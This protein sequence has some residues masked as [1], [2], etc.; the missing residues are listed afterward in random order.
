MFF[1]IV[2]IFYNKNTEK[3]REQSDPSVRKCKIRMAQL[4]QGI[5]LPC[6]L[7]SNHTTM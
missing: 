2:P 4:D 1:S 5:S 7:N 6:N 3:A